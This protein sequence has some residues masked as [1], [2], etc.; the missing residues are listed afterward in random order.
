MKNSE[1]LIFIVGATEAGTA[2]IA[3]KLAKELSLPLLERPQRLGETLIRPWG[4]QRSGVMDIGGYLPTAQELEWMQAHGTILYAEVS[5][6]NVFSQRLAA[7]ESGVS[8]AKIEEEL[9]AFE[10]A[11]QSLAVATLS[12]E[13]TTAVAQIAKT[14]GLPKEREPA[15]KREPQSPVPV[16]SNGNQA[17][18]G[19]E[20][21][22]KEALFGAEKPQEQGLDSEESSPDQ[23]EDLSTPEKGIEVVVGEPKESRFKKRYLVLPLVALLVVGIFVAGVSAYRFIHQTIH[24]I[25]YQPSEPKYQEPEGTL[26]EMDSKVV[27]VLL[28]GTDEQGPEFS[29]GARADSIMIAS[30]NMGTG[31]ARL[32]SLERGIGV[33]IEGVGED[34]LTHVFAYGGADLMVQTV[35]EQFDVDLHHYARVN[36]SAFE[37]IIDVLGG[38]TIDLTAE[39][40][41]ALESITQG[42]MQEGET[43]LNGYDALQYARLR[44]ID[45]DFKRVERQRNIIQALIYE[46]QDITMYEL[47]QLSQEVLPLV[48]TNIPPEE[49]MSLVRYAPKFRGVTLQQMTIPE[50]EDI[51]P[52]IVLE[53]GRVLTRIDFDACREKIYEFLYWDAPEGTKRKPKKRT[54]VLGESSEHSGA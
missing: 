43:F 17:E 21:I 3:Q 7:G 50:K 32:V 12:A 1:A 49:L 48:Q 28:L 23:P 19:S 37:K 11:F 47:Y 2:T 8:S 40:A 53:D 42:K 52:G 33:P 35:R 6:D 18:E 20:K 45:S 14:L 38:V 36:F 46:F 31:S 41:Q 15:E 44:S 29:E 27:N 24:R 51:L 30:A 13:D 39:E 4:D 22:E 5:S 34:W 26:M 10:Q 54:A 25:Q 9:W 16:D